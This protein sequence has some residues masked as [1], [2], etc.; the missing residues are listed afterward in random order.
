MTQIRLLTKNARLAAT[1]QH[2]LAVT[3][4][5]WLSKDVLTNLDKVIQR[6]GILFVH[7]LSDYYWDLEQKC[8]QSRWSILNQRHLH[9]GASFYSCFQVFFQ[10]CLWHRSTGTRLD[11]AQILHRISSMLALE[12]YS[13]W[14]FF[15]KM[16]ESCFACNFKQ[17]RW[18]LILAYTYL[19]LETQRVCCPV[20]T[21]HHWSPTSTL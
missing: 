9:L 6:E 13:S 12:S 7:A 15:L 11:T 8:T 4:K 1:C 20:V 21:E 3:N 16:K 18:L 2:V 17:P 5:A 14:F 10:Q 19:G